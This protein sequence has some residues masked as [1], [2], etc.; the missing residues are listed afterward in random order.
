VCF[1]DMNLH[2]MQA[3]DQHAC[4]KSLPCCKFYTRP[5]PRVAAATIASFLSCESFPWPR[6]FEYTCI[7]WV[8]ATGN[9]IPVHLTSKSGC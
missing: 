2:R 3:S 9:I 6:K 5:I 7:R 4:L 1:V 8:K